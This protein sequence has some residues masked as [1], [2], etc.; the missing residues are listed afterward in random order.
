ML[1]TGAPTYPAPLPSQRTPRRA[2]RELSA[3]AGRSR[4]QGALQA[5]QAS[6]GAAG[7]KSLS[8][9][10]GPQS[11]TC[12]PRSPSG[13]AQARAAALQALCRSR[14]APGAPRAGLGEAGRRR[15]GPCNP[16]PGARSPPPPAPPRQLRRQLPLFAPPA[17]PR[18]GATRR[19]SQAHLP[20]AAGEPCRWA[21]WR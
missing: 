5:S 19:A 16:W 8:E 1:G 6:L 10:P 15:G 21:A 4:V 13:E 12:P 3:A 11:S 9:P 2:G 14:A 7:C 17:W 18:P 20:S